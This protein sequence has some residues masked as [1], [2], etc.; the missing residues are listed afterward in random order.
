MAL[1]VADENHFC[2]HL[3]RNLPFGKVLQLVVAPLG[4]EIRSD[5]A[6]EIVRGAFREQGDQIDAL[7]SCHNLSTFEFWHQR[8]IRP[9]VGTYRFV[10]IEG[11]EKH[12]TGGA[13]SYTMELS[14]YDPVPG[15]VQQQLQSDF[16][17]A[18][19]ED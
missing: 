8:T 15:N 10:G 19:D 11:N 1:L 5:A 9:L 18:P 17:P 6:Q 14:H 13:G 12:V 4:I 7:E 16:K 3:P 2:A